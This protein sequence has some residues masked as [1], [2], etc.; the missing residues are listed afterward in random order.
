MIPVRREEKGSCSGHGHQRFPDL[1][2][3]NIVD[4][5]GGN[6]YAYG[7]CAESEYESRSCFEVCLVHVKPL[8]LLSLQEL[9]DEDQSGRDPDCDDQ[10]S[11]HQ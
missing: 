10:G 3:G 2:P 6:E 7:K 9:S 4:D 5:D 1:L 11:D 8:A